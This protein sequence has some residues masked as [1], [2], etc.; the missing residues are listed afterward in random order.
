[1]VVSIGTSPKQIEI[2]EHTPQYLAPELL[3]YDVGRELW[4]AYG[5]KNGG[6]VSV[7]FPTPRTNQ[8]WR[9]N[10]PGWVGHIPLSRGYSLTITPKVHLRN[11]L[12]MWEYAYRLRSF[13]LIDDVSG[14]QSLLGFYEML[15]QILARRVLK[16]VNQGLFQAYVPHLGRLSYVRGRLRLTD[17]WRSPARVRLDC[18]YEEFTPDIPENQ[19]LLFTLHQVARGQLCGSRVQQLVRGAYLALHGP[20]ATGAFRPSDCNALSYSRLNQDYRPLHAIC[21]FLLEHSGSLPQSGPRPMM[22]FLINMARLYELFVAEWM[23]VNLPAEYILKPQERVNIDSAGSYHFKIDL[24]LYHQDSETPVAVLDTKY[25]VPDKASA[26]EVAQVV[27]YAQAK[28]SPRAILIY[29]AALSIPLDARIGRSV[30]VR[31]LCF[32]LDGDLEEA[33]RRFMETLFSDESRRANL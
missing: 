1:M 25:R 5:E 7:E 14:V 31:S 6:K 15:A 23:R 4:E 10:A 28:S 9:L 27:A 20:V 19:I 32:P 8:R 2:I 3:P 18:Q 30:H 13:H 21:R 16:R 17:Q 24:V 12:R 11:L 22:P 26:D 33:G 29:P